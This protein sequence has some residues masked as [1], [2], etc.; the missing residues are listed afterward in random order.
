MKKEYFNND[1]CIVVQG[2]IDYIENIVETYEKFK[3]NVIISTNQI[4]PHNLQYLYS[5]GF[6]V[7]INELSVNPGKA[8]FNNQVK[9]TYEGIKMADKLKFNYVF[10][11]RSDIFIDDLSELINSLNQNT[12]Y[13]SAYH[14]YDGGYLCEHMLFGPV[15]FMLNLWNIPQ[16]D[17]NL[18]PETQLTL[19]YEEINN[20]YSLDFI[21]PILYSKKIK[22]YWPKHQKYLNEYETDKLFTYEK[23]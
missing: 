14:N 5:K 10:K 21:F 3:N 20:K 23:K 9:N 17:S 4:Q 11:I 12:V 16:S 8:N 13:F 6:K 2:P 7:I 22:A 15:D 1:I 18:P 19:K